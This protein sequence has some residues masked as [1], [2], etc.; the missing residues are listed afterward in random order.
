MKKVLILLFLLMLSIT[1][2]QAEKISRYVVL[3]TSMEDT[4]LILM[5]TINMYSGIVELDKYDKQQHIYTVTYNLFKPTAIYAQPQTQQNININSNEV[6]NNNGVLNTYTYGGF[7]CQLKQL[8]DKDILLLCRKY[9]YNM[10]YIYSHYKKYYRELRLNGK[11]VIPYKNY[12]KGK[13]VR[14]DRKDLTS[15]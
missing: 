7:S 14:N 12:L 9:C 4:E 11:Q 15:I 6:S 8:N 10:D 5:N 1:Q 3:D 2:V 13:Y